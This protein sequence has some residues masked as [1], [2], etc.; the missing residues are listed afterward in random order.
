MG[1]EG[2]GGRWCWAILPKVSRSFAL[3]ISLLPRPLDAQLMIAYLLYRAIDTIEDCPAPAEEKRRMF[4]AI[5]AQMRNGKRSC[6][7]RILKWAGTK[8]EKELISGLDTLMAEY[9]ALPKEI[10]LSIF[11]W[12]KVMAKGMSEFLGKDITTFRE[13]NKYSYYV[14]GVVGYL[15]NDLLFYNK[16]IDGKL[17]RRLRVHA[18]R[19]GLALQ[20]INILRDVAADVR[21][22]RFYWPSDTLARYGLSYETLCL[23]ENRKRA[24][25]VLE[26]QINESK[27]YINSAMYYTL[28]LPKNAVRVRMFCAIPLFM[29]IESFAKCRGNEGVFDSGKTVKISR[30]KVY[31]IVA[32]TW[33]FGKFNGLMLR[34]YMDSMALKEMPAPAV[35]ADS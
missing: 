11:R 15:I 12:G 6:S 20:K 7:G 13:Q 35:P 10:R 1:T 4:S 8:N 34:W 14:A 16:I 22:R 32:K 27:S 24:M 25:K 30:L 23:P 28:S 26:R 31:E 33:L 19:F 29:A 5:L 18:K 9:R 2:E 3:C 17:K 21:D